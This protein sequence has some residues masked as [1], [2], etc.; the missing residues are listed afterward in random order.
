MTDHE[1]WAVWTLGVVAL[2]TVAYFTIVTLRGDG[3]RVM[4]IFALLALTAVPK[5]SRRGFT[6]PRLDE[7]EQEITHKALLTSFRAMWVMLVGLLVIMGRAKGVDGM[8]SLW[9][10]AEALWWLGMLALAVQAA[11]TLVLYRR[12]SHA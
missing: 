4:G 12:G 2:T 8:V 5:H 3:P 9:K 6:G 7:R 1:K 11:T 10:L